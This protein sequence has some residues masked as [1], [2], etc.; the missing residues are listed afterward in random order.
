MHDEPR[1]D[2]E[3]RALAAWT[4]AE[5]PADFTDRVLRAAA[6]DPRLRAAA[7]PSLD[8]PDIPPAAALR[9]D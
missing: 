4:P 1:S 9:W 8:A 2:L 3:Q 6:A 5:P 7:L